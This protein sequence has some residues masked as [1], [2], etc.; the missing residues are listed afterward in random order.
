LSIIT[1]VLIAGLGGYFLTSIQTTYL[2]VASTNDIQMIQNDLLAIKKDGTILAI[3]ENRREN[4][5]TLFCRQK[6]EDIIV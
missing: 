2:N 3:S 6:G 5:N 4:V 1:I